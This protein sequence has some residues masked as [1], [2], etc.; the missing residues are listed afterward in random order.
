MKA[1]GRKA[2]AQGRTPANKLAE[3][4]RAEILT[5]AN[6]PQFVHL[7]PSQIVPRLADEGRYLASESSFQRYA[8]LA[9]DSLRRA[10]NKVSDKIAQAFV[11]RLFGTAD[12]NG[13][14]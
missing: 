14:A 2:G 3:A 7:P 10:T 1:D 8:H 13:R 12:R 5:T 9:S 11:F 4:E 6:A